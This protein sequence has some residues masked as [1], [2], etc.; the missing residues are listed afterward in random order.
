MTTSLPSTPPQSSPS[1]PSMLQME[2]KWLQNKE[3]RLTHILVPDEN[4]VRHWSKVP[5]SYR[6]FFRCGTTVGM[7]NVEFACACSETLWQRHYV[8]TLSTLDP[9]L[10][11]C[12]RPRWRSDHLVLYLP[13]GMLGAFTSSPTNID[14]RSIWNLIA[15]KEESCIPTVTLSRF[16]VAIKKRFRLKATFNVLALQWRR[17]KTANVRMI[18]LHALTR[19]GINEVELRIIIATLAGLW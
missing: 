19:R 12:M 8:F 3:F 6:M 4:A 15:H 18:V 7:L 11:E 17:A 14:D 13:D 1:F 16:F 9:L 5:A 10:Q 2:N